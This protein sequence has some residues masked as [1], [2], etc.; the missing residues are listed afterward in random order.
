M[1]QILLLIP[2]LLA[3]CGEKAAKPPAPPAHAETIAHESEL[4]KLTLTPQAQQ[5]LGIA[6]ARVGGGSASATRE[7]A[8]EIVVPPIS[9]NGV[10]V[11]STTNL[12]Q[13]GSQQAAADAELAR[14]MA[15]ARLARIALDRAE[16]LVREEAGSVRARDEAAAA[17]AAAQA[18]L[19][20]A[21]QQ[22][23]LLGPAVGSLGAQPV[24]WVRASVF[25]SDMG[26]VRRSDSA[27]VRTLGDGGVPRAARP[28]QAPPSANTV[29]GTVDLYYAV[30]NRDRA[31][32]VG[33]RVAVDL[34]LVGQTEGL[35]VP[36]AAILRD[37]Y[38]GEWVY[39]RTAPN[40]F[41]RQR[42]EV[43]S[44]N[45]GRAL[46]SRGLTVGAQVVTGGAA[47]LFGTEFGA[48]H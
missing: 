30:D 2:I 18:A 39:Q 24:L 12:Q 19:G 26:D 28:V 48:A 45:D 9:A 35:S 40:T 32:R 20:A 42:V 22:R 21:R 8:G 25:G 3:A 34:P 46:L 15:Q 6:L 44:E 23:R 41:V 17:L 7:V 31:F 14:A 4:L 13:I 27:T 33:Q 16:S 10:P 5:R 43:A 29:A 1:R 36:S 11:N 47:E 38:G 37:V